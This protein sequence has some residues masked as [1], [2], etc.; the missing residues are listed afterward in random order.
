MSYKPSN[1][2]EVWTFEMMGSASPRINAILSR[3]FGKAVGGPKR[4]KLFRGPKSKLRDKSLM[5]HCSKC[6]E[7]FEH[8]P[9]IGQYAECPY[10]GTEGRELGDVPDRDR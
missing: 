8:T 6:D 4:G 1:L 3:E 2:K 10:C 7:K 9:H 5:Y